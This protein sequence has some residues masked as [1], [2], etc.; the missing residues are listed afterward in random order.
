MT[1]IK[2]E[3]RINSRC[4]PSAVVSSTGSIIL[5]AVLVFGFTAATR[6]EFEFKDAALAKCVNQLASKKGWLSAQE[7]TEVVCHNKGIASAEDC[8]SQQWP[9]GQTHIDPEA[10]TGNHR[11]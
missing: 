9:D 6:A 3:A 5:C 4:R 10:P 1:I 7:V 2:G 8:Q 11:H